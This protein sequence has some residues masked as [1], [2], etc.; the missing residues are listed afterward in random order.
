MRSWIA[1]YEIVGP[2]APDETAPEQIGPAAGAAP[3]LGGTWIARPP[4]RLGVGDQV[5][6]RVVPV[7]QERQ[8]ERLLARLRLMA[9][10]RA[11]Q[12]VRLVE[13]GRDESDGSFYVSQSPYPPQTLARP[14]RPLD[15]RAIVLAVAAAARGAHQLHEAGVVH[16][17]ISPSQVVLSDRGPLLEPLGPLLPQPPGRVVGPEDRHHLELFDPALLW[18]GAPSRATDVWSLG[19]TLHEALGG[20]PLHAG[21]GDEPPAT[22]LQRVLLEPPTIDPALAKEPAD[23]IHACLA[24][25]PAERP[26]TAA[27]VADRLDQLAMRP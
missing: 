27:I 15:E 25:N 26:A 9:A 4:A 22:A 10:V 18:G 17:A 23:L 21:L 5:V 14:G 8:V 20:A 13:A 11:P 12:L 2:L 24:A 3:G 7:S 19:A 1:D 6:L 16:G